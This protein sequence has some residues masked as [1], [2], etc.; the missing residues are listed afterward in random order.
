MALQWEKVRFKNAQV[1][2]KK[3][4]L[5]SEKGNKYFLLKLQRSTAEVSSETKTVSCDT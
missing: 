4:F 3:T 1:N 2:I 5:A